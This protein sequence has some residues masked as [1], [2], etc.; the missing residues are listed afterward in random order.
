MIFHGNGA[1]EF[2]K[3]RTETSK[4]AQLA[5]HLPRRDDDGVAHDPGRDRAQELRRHRDGFLLLSPLRS[6]PPP[7]P[8]AAALPPS[9][10][11]LRLPQRLERRDRLVVHVRC[12]PARGHGRQGPPQPPP[13][14]RRVL[15]RGRRLRHCLRRAARRGPGAF[16]SPPLLLNKLINAQRFGWGLRPPRRAS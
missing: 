10:P 5:P 12:G 8:A 14:R 16:I 7:L 11:E 6:G 1:P 2:T 3:N 4:E 13:Q 9:G 15:V